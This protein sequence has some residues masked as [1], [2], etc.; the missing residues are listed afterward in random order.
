MCPYATAAGRGQPAQCCR[1]LQLPQIEDA[2]VENKLSIITAEGVVYPIDTTNVVRTFVRE[3]GTL[4]DFGGVP[5][6]YGRR[7]D[8]L[9]KGYTNGEGIVGFPFGYRAFW[10]EGGRKYPREEKHALLDVS[11][12]LL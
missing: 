4:V 12:A 1:V 3:G 9:V 5:C 2:E 10:S 7:D 6:Y 8:K 11:S